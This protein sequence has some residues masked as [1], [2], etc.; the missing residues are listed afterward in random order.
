MI[1]WGFFLANWV[2]YGSQYYN[3]TRQFRVPLGIQIIPA[4]ILLLGMFF[5]PF[6]PRWLAKRGRVDEARQVLLR[7]HGGRKEDR[8]EVVEAEILYMVTQVE[9]G[10]YT[11]KMSLT[12]H[13]T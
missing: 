1:C 9:W 8:A 2:G 3:D 7:L 5:L 11:P 10:E 4:A 12:V 13:R 6:S